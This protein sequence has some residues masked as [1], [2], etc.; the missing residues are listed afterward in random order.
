MSIHFRES[1]IHFSLIHRGRTIMLNKISKKFCNA[2]FGRLSSVP[3]DHG[4]AVVTQ[5]HVKGDRY[6]IAGPLFSGVLPCPT[7]S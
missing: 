1:L 6:E 2:S 3:K 5:P 7:T 4:V